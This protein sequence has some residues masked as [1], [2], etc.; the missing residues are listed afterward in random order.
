M[1]VFAKITHDSFFVLVSV[2]CKQAIQVRVVSRVEIVAQESSPESNGEGRADGIFFCEQADFAV[3]EAVP[4]GSFGLVN[5]VTN[6]Y[7]TA[8][9]VEADFKAFSSFSEV[10]PATKGLGSKIFLFH[11][12]DSPFSI[13]LDLRHPTLLGRWDSHIEK[14]IR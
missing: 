4:F 11:R 1:A 3:H 9:Q 13:G 8:L 12:D 14:K 5:E 10:A 7:R 2:F 6:K